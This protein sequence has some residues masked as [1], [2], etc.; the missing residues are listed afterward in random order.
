VT[1]LQSVL[2]EDLPHPP[3]AWGRSLRRA[4]PYLPMVPGMLFLVGVS[5]YPTIYSLIISLYRWNLTDSGGGEFSGL[6][7][8]AV[9]LSDD[10][11]WNSVFVTGKFVAISV[12]AEFVLGM[13]MALLFFRRFPGDRFIRAMLILPMV[14]APIVVALMS[15]YMLNVQF[16]VVNYLL[17]LLGIGRIDFLGNPN[18]A[19]ATL[20]GIDI[21]Q[22]TP[23]MFL[24]LLAA[25]QGIPEDLIEA[26]RIDGAGAI[27][28]FKDHILILLRYPIAVAL[29]LRL[30]D[31]FRVYD[32]I[33]MTT[34]GGP[35]DATQTLSWEVYDAG[36]KSFDMGYAAAYSWLM[37][38]IVVVTVTVVLRLTLGRSGLP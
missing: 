7:N 12:S 28:I 27:R 36:F 16:G 4:S 26:A 19:L 22:W 10:S 32:I 17:D 34:H 3:R 13:G 25:L 33:Y 2:H 30:I 37:L 15:R 5:L 9:L 1:Q 21:W 24:I 35:V 14:V 31:S 11:F 8:Y 20:I 18:T 23:F 38:V 29:A 6:H